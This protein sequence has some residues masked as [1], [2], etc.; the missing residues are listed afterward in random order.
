MR[1]GSLFTSPRTLPSYLTL[2]HSLAADYDW[3]AVLCYHT[4]FFNRRACEMEANGPHPPPT[5]ANSD[6]LRH[7]SAVLLTVPSPSLRRDAL[8]QTPGA[9]LSAPDAATQPPALSDANPDIDT[10][11]NS[12]LMDEGGGQSPGTAFT[13][14]HINHGCAFYA[15]TASTPYCG[16]V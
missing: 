9:L 2:L 11:I 10:R 7:P 12:I 16:R 13:Y 8:I 1:T 6:C 5:Y 4:L 15:A 14:F 3:D